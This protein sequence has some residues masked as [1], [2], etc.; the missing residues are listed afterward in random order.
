M[1]KKSGIT[2]RLR[3]STRPV[4]Y[5]VNT[6]VLLTELSTASGRRVT[7]ATIPDSLID[8]WAGL[9]IDAV[10]LMGVWTSGPRGVEIARNHSGLKESYRSALPDLKDEDIAGSPYAVSAYQVAERLGGDKALK[11]FRTRL[12]E[13]GI[14]LILD[15]VPNHTARDHPWV[16]SHPEYYIAGREGEEMEKPDHFFTTATD[17]GKRTIAYG[18]DPG[19]AGWTDTAQLNPRHP[20]ARRMMIETLSHIASMCDGVRCDMAML[21]LNSVFER[22]WGDHALPSGSPPADGEFW[23]EAISTVRK[24]LPDFLFIAEAYWN[25]EWELQ[26]LEFNYTYDKTLYDRL[27]HEGAGAVRDHLRAEVEYQKHSLRFIENHDEPRAA[28]AFTSDSWQYAAATVAATVPG[29]VMFHEGQLDGR[30]VRVPV[31]LTRRP[32]EVC[33]ARTRAFYER[34]LSIVSSPVIRKGT[35]QMLM[36]KGAWHDNYTWQNFLAF[37]W[38]HAADGHRLIVVNYAPLSGQCYID[39]PLDLIKGHTLEFRDLMGEAV[40]A[41]DRAGLASKGMYFDLPAYGIHIFEV[42][43]APRPTA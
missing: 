8:E 3:E 16:A 31:Q 18:R 43:S 2:F 19:Y 36:S 15:F 41:R 27:L 30:T 23:T 29:M 17:R 26:Q 32:A 33:A 10:W 6:R 21:V 7:L 39:L 11:T 20:E 28:R 40:Y 22:T 37:W 38:H 13:R 24:S 9:G 25:L 1:A 34:L 4:L 5:E 42:T 14:A 12:S 35:W